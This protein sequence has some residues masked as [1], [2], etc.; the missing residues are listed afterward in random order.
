MNKKLGICIVGCGYMGN[1]HAGCWDNNPGTEIVAVV[2]LDESRADKMATEYKLDGY[3]TDYL[4]AIALPEVDIVSVC[5]PTNLHAEVTIAAAELGKHVLCEKPI[6]LTLE[7]SDRMIAAAA[8]NKVKLGLGF[9][10]RH[11]PVLLALKQQ[12]TSGKFGR[13]VL[14]NASDVRELRPKRAMHD[15]DTNGGPVVDMAVHLIDLWTFIFDSK[16]VSVSAQGL[17][18]ARD[19]PEVNHIDRVAI[20]TAALTVKFDSG[21]IGNFVVS[22]GLPPKVTPQ[23]SPDQIYGPDGLGEVYYT[24]NKQELRLMQEGAAWLTLSVSHQDMYQNQIDKFTRWVLE[25]AV[26]PATGE[27]GKSALRV[28]LG[29]LEAIR[30]RENN[31]SMI[32]GIIRMN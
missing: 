5:V 22:W 9:M 3:F 6:T 21:D 16:P 12:L 1:I 18:L 27:D 28:A 31:I 15:A 29:A 8:E 30:Y 32:L 11:S 4:D 23:G 25:D 19:R 10:R 13:P 26:F 7:A 17:S 14:Y 20:D 2:D 24:R